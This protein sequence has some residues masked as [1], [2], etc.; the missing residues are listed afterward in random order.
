MGIHIHRYTQK[1]AMYSGYTQF[2]SG[3]LTNQQVPIYHIELHGKMRKKQHTVEN[4]TSI[5]RFQWVYI[6]IYMYIYI[7][8]LYTHTHTQEL[9]LCIHIST[10]HTCI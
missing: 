7:Y 6:Y 3:K 10:I 4:Q 5:R 8:V 1:W 2:E 9:A